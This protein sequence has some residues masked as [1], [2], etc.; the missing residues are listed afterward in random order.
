MR[1][2]GLAGRKSGFGGYKNPSRGMKTVQ[3]FTRNW[4]IYWWDGRP[5]NF[6]SKRLFSPVLHFTVLPDAPITV[7][8]KLGCHQTLLDNST[9]C[10][11]KNRTTNGDLQ[12]GRHVTAAFGDNSATY[13]YHLVDCLYGIIPYI[14]IGAFNDSHR[15][16]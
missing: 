7:P 16:P 13:S 11:H 5:P 15:P 9:V 10:P 8:S 4:L 12:R 1:R 14:R 2:D 6:R 3:V